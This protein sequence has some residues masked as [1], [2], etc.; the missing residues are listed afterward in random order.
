M[1]LCQTPG[2]K[3]LRVLSPSLWEAWKQESEAPG[4]TVPTVRRQKLDK[5]GTEL[6]NLK[7]YPSDNPQDPLPVGDETVKHMSLWGNTV[8]KLL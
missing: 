2:R 6:K 4:H 3:L 7:A 5:K 1:L 8:V